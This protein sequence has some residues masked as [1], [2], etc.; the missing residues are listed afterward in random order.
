MLLV[1]LRMRLV[2]SIDCW[3]SRN[4]SPGDGAAAPVPSGR[5]EDRRDL[6]GRGNSQRMRHGLV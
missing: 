1:S 6:D 5:A 2:A 4:F 3:R